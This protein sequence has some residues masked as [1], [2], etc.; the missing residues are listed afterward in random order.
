MSRA[1]VDISGSS[2][3]AASSSSSGGDNAQKIKLAAAGGVLLVAIA[4][5]GWQMGWFESSPGSDAAPA[6]VVEAPV[7]PE[8][9]MQEDPNNPGRTFTEEPAARPTRKGGGLIAPGYD[10]NAP[11]NNPP[12]EPPAEPPPGDGGGGF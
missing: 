3:A 12:A 8:Q 11:E 9:I 1:R 6:A 7:P 4:A 5:I 2:K 10:P